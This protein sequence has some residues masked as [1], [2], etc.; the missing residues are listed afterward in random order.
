MFISPI[1]VEEVLLASGAASD[2]KSIAVNFYETLGGLLRDYA[3]PDKDMVIDGTFIPAELKY[4]VLGTY[5]MGHK[6]EELRSMFDSSFSLYNS[7]IDLEKDISKS[8]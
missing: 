3:D 8:I 4:E 6:T 1:Q 5:L 2:M 7:V